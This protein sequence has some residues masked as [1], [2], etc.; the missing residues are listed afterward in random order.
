MAAA[1]VLCFCCRVDC[2]GGDNS[3][4]VLHGGDGDV[5]SCGGHGGSGGSDNTTP[6]KTIPLLD[7]AVL[8][9]GG[10]VRHGLNSFLFVYHYL[11][12]M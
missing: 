6:H 7:C 5:V 9:G 10:V 12:S 11:P 3:A 8:C 2:G 4:A 1:A